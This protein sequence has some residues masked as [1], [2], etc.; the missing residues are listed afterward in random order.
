[1]ASQSLKLRVLLPI[2]SAALLIMVS[3]ASTAH[4]ATTN[5]Y[6]ASPGSGANLADVYTSPY[7]GSV[8]G[9]AGTLIPVICDDFANNSYIPEDWAAYVTPYS[10]TSLNSSTDTQVMWTGA[11]YDPN[12]PS[13]T[14]KV[15]STTYNDWNLTQAQAYTVAAVLAIDILNSSGTAQQ[16]Y[17]YALWELFDPSQVV[18]WLG[19]SYQSVLMAASSDVEAAITA[20]AGLTPA[21]FSNVTIYTYDPPPPTGTGI[22]PKCGTNLNTSCPTTPP[23]E[24]IVVTPEPASLLL[25]GTGLLGIIV[26]TRR[27]QH[28]PAVGL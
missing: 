8:T 20:A 10:S 22:T 21:S 7:T 16:D 9:P 6:L 18:S 27:K 15:G 13:T 25:F 19:S 12:P 14:F 23:Q 17:S 1:M 11:S 2:F 24:F 26:V 3:V 28:R 4:A 5:F